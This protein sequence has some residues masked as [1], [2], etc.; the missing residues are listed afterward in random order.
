MDNT[1]ERLNEVFREVFDNEELSVTPATT[2]K[3]IEGWDSLMHVTLI[4]NVEKAFGVRFT[5]YRTATLVAAGVHARP[6]TAALG[7]RP[8]YT[9]ITAVLGARKRAQLARLTAAGI[10]PC[11]TQGR[12]ERKRPPIRTGRCATCP[13]RSTWPG[14][15]SASCTKFVSGGTSIP[16]PIL[17]WQPD[18]DCW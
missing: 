5:S 7:T 3:D 16:M 2:A 9:P 4:V 11:R 8:D 10:R 12:W 6:I 17:A 18:V 13:S 14:P 15:P 1:L